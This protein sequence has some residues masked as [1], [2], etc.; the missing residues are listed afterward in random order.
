MLASFI[1]NLTA[2]DGPTYKHFC[3]CTAP[4]EESTNILS[5]IELCF[6]DESSLVVC[7]EKV[8]EE[9]KKLTAVMKSVHVR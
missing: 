9:L 1:T 5:S 3:R 8:A 4:S 2:Q 7:K 6:D